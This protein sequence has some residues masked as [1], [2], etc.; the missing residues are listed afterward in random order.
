M[1]RTKP[2]VM[3]V[4][5][6]L[7]SPSTTLPDSTNNTQTIGKRKRTDDAVEAEDS[8]LISDN[9]PSSEKKKEYLK[10]LLQDMLEVLKTYV[11]LGLSAVF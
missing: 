7:S 1:N 9:D 10:G 4:P 3:S 5:N 2:L 6:G 8:S 11:S